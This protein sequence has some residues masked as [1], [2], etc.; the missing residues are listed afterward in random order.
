MC[1]DS[2]LWA[3]YCHS[4]NTGD[5]PALNEN[6]K[7]NHAAWSLFIK[8]VSAYVLLL[9]YHVFDTTFYIIVLS[10][11][12]LQIAV[13]KRGQSFKSVSLLNRPG[14]SVLKEDETN[15]NKVKTGKMF[16]KPAWQ[17]I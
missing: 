8:T 15:T 13:T 5:G 14:V 11:N 1:R 10:F 17:I 2:G 6:L 9:I 4:H 16:I 12:A 3:L 7:Y